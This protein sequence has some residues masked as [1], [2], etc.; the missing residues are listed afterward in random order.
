MAQLRSSRSKVMSILAKI[1]LFATSVRSGLDDQ[2]KAITYGDLKYEI[3]NWHQVMPPICLSLEKLNHMP[4]Y[5]TDENDEA[6]EARTAAACVQCYGLACIIYL[7]RITTRRIGSAAFNTEVKTAA[8]RIIT[9]MGRFTTGID[10]LATLWPLL[11]V[12]IATVD[13]Y[14]QIALRQRL[15]GMECFGLMYVSRVLQAL[16]YS[17]SDGASYAELE[18]MLSSNLVP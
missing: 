6:I 16:Q 7:E 18:A 11:T 3:A 1:S 14:Q 12:G 8:D 2:R 4:G 10:Q 15:V 9:L 13:P 5:E 17:W